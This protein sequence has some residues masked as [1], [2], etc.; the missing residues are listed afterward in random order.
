MTNSAWSALSA[1]LAVLE[2]GFRPPVDDG[3]TDK[4]KGENKHKIN[5][6]ILPVP[7]VRL[8]LWGSGGEEE[9]RGGGVEGRGSGG[10]GEWR[11]GGVEGRRSG[12]EEKRWTVNTKTQLLQREIPKECL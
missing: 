10:E 4:G 11:E 12:E 2:R 9:W 8:V 1:L 3:L 5:V 6:Q 7:Q